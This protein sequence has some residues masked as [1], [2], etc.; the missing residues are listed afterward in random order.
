MIACARACV[1][2]CL[3]SPYPHPHSSPPT[4]TSYRPPP[5][6]TPS[7]YRAPSLFLETLLL[8]PHRTALA[9]EADYFEP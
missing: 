1:R 3:Q 4:L 6:L 5:P 7:R 9:A 8:P 2:V